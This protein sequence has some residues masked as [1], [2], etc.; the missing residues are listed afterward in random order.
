MKSEFGNYIDVPEVDDIRKHTYQM[1]VIKVKEETNRD[2]L[3]EH[4]RSQGIGA[5]V[6]F[7]PPVHQQTFYKNKYKASLPIT[8]KVCKQ[9]ITLPMFPQLKKEEMDYMI[10]QI[11]KFFRGT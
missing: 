2:S 8:E 1:F 6:H 4:L 3:L 11:R 7:E 5:S 10:E 9:I